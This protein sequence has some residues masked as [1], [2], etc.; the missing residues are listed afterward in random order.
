MK[1]DQRIAA[2][3]A[4]LDDGRIKVLSVDVFDTLLWRCVPE[5]FDVFLL[6]GRAL[7]NDG[8]LAGDL[9]AVQ[10]AELRREAEKTARARREAATGSREI[11]LADIYSEL[12]DFLFAEEFARSRRIARELDLERGLMCLDIELADLMRRAKA[13]G[14]KVH[15]VSD[16]YFGAAEI[17][18]F[19][20]A[21][22][23]TVADICDDVIVSCEAGR[24]KWRDL[25]P[26][27]LKSWTVA[28]VDVT[29]VGDKI[30]ADVLPAQRAGINAVHYDK[31]SVPRMETREWPQALGARAERLADAGDLGLTGLRARLYHRG[32]DPFWRY[33]A[34]ILAP[35][36]AAFARWIVRSAA[37]AGVTTVYGIMREG[38]FLKRVIE[39][40]ARD[41]GVALTVDELWLSRRAVI[42]AAF[43]PETP[44]L[45]TEFVLLTP[46]RTTDEILANM[47]LSRA[48]PALAGFDIGAPNALM[49]L[50]QVIAR[51]AAVRTKV[52]A[53]A[54]MLRANLLNG[55]GRVID[56]GATSPLIVVDLGY[57]ATI[58][59]VLGKILKAAGHRRAVSGFYFA[60]NEKAVGNIL[61][62]TDARA[63]LTQGGYAAGAVKALT[64]TT[65]VL[66]HACMCN[67]GTLSHYDAAGAPVL[68]A[69]QR[70]ATQLEQMSAMQYGIMAGVAAINAL[71]GRRD[72]APEA[73]ASLQS[74]VAAIIEAAM[75]YPTSE[76]A[77]S[78]GA[79]KHEAKV[80]AMPAVAF[81]DLAF[82]ATELEYGGWDAL[83]RLGRDQVYWPA[84]ALH[85]LGTKAVEAYAGGATG[86]YSSS[87]LNADP[88]LGVIQ[89]CPDLGIGFDERRQ[90]AVPLAVNAFGRGV[91]A[92]TLKGPTPEAYVKLRLRWPAARAAI[93][94]DR[95]VVHFD[96]D[97]GRRSVTLGGPEIAWSGGEAAGGAR[98]VGGAAETVL[99]LSRHV[100]PGPHGLDL[101]VRFKYLRLDPLFATS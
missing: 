96:A 43:G 52:F 98:I 41:L 91:V 14:V 88:L 61:G 75:L 100:P 23:A 90:G 82:D 2:I 22:G 37:A 20:A 18:G 56:L 16:T 5:P 15:L 4:R 74:N 6:L 53:W 60:L 51:D 10:F 42:R 67:E 49:Q 24:P 79:W 81:T 46:G 32:G 12:P 30:E 48:E 9:S 59:A 19:V 55:L 63:Y 25:F 69:N 89:I 50:C 29:H 38:R 36:L 62:G 99:D 47:G 76:E 27:L 8:L 92:A 40:A 21:V 13:R 11:V 26:H 66:E 84:A 31:W 71:I 39:A 34:A 86:A 54:A 73:A 28:A 57:M 58:Q 101:E 87:V 65:D 1:A 83:Q 97:G 95:V 85:R 72:E 80:D 3:D 94:I 64:R 7:K 78:I 68:I 17:S 77:T 44:E 70:S 45:L 35:V 33:G 93:G